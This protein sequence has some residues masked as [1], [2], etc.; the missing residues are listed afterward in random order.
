[1]REA[2][3]DFFDNPSN[4]PED[5][6]L[7]YY[8][9]H[10]IPDPYGDVFLASSEIDP[11]RPHR[12][13]FSFGDLTQAINRSV[14]IRIVTILDCCYSG[15]ARV[16]K[17][18]KRG[19]EESVV[20]V[21]RSAMNTKA[22]ILHQGEGKYLLAAS[23]AAQEAY[24]LEE[25]GHSIFTYYL[26]EGLKGNSNS[27]D[28]YGNVTPSSLSNYIYNE[29]MNLP[30]RPK[31]KPLTKGEV[32]GDIILT[33]HPDLA[34]PYLPSPPTTLSGKSKTKIIFIPIF[35]VGGIIAIIFGI[36][37]IGI[38]N[39]PINYDQEPVVDQ[40]SNKSLNVYETTSKTDRLRQIVPSKPPIVHIDSNKTDFLSVFLKANAVSTDN[41]T[42]SSIDFGDGNKINY[43]HLGNRSFHHEYGSFYNEY[44][45]MREYVGTNGEVYGVRTQFERNYPY[46]EGDSYYPFMTYPLYT[47]PIKYTYAKPGEYLIKI[48]VNDTDGQSNYTT[49]KV[50]LRNPVLSG[51]KVGPHPST[52][53]VDIKNNLVYVYN[54]YKGGSITIING[55]TDRFIGNVA[56]GIKEMPDY[57]NPI[58]ISINPNSSNIYVNHIKNGNITV[59]NGTDYSIIRTIDLKSLGISVDPYAYKGT[60]A[61]VNP[62][63][64]MIYATEYADYYDKNQTVYI[65]NGTTNSIVQTYN[66]TNYISFSDGENLPFSNPLTNV[67]YVQKGTDKNLTLSIINGTTN[68][69]INIIPINGTYPLLEENTNRLYLFNH[70]SSTSKQDKLK[71]KVMDGSSGKQVDIIFLPSVD[72]DDYS[73]Y[74]PQ[75][76]NSKIGKIYSFGFEQQ[77]NFGG[78]AQTITGMDQ[79]IVT[80]YRNN[81]ETRIDVGWDP[82]GISINPKTNRIYVTNYD[83]NTTS[84][85]DGKT[86]K[87][88]NITTFDF[89]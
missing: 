9:G 44:D 84:I 88:I 70:N 42:S 49:W 22:N 74:Y 25:K 1:M 37:A 32:S 63:T 72:N 69:L 64:D 23:Q 18:G 65:I 71:V 85:I 81:S 10:G 61:H 35:L 54:R 52:I 12:R 57:Y 77:S 87:R 46:Q 68:S 5:T 60:S 59:I 73:Y 58:K 30:K 48:V 36:N 83:S 2:I 21:A 41:L 15:A 33:E 62:I 26:L 11:D 34:K 20:N 80:D 43:N 78:Q 45:G 38:T 19:N 13:G 7:F 56:L 4:K 29:L 40:T 67:I 51:I 6:L 24:G 79:L 75:A 50:D 14:S 8:S 28:I 39:F 53:E 89:L 76:I 55:T 82:K 3:Y 31:Q 27:V 66:T 86:D 16:S 17:G 47:N